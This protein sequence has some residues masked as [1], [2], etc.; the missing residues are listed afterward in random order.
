MVISAVFVNQ[1]PAL[2]CP[3]LL[4]FCKIIVLILHCNAEQANIAIMSI[5]DKTFFEL[6]G[7]TLVAHNIA[8]W[9]EPN[10]Y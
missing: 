4:I 3:T 7:L 8:V 10:N 2:Q 5:V 9:Y 6:C 1:V